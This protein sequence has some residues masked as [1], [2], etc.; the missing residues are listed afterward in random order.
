MNSNSHQR[1]LVHPFLGEIKLP[2]EA[3]LSLLCSE[4]VST[5]LE[6]DASNGVYFI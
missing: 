2:W 3:G 5:P 1:A 6:A 4:A